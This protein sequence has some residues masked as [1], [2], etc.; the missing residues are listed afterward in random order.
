MRA[1]LPGGDFFLFLINSDKKSAVTD[2]KNGN[3]LLL[4]CN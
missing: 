1:A 3:I 4:K 2:K